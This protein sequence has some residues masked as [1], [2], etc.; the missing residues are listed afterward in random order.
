MKLAAKLGVAF[1][2]IT[3]STVLALFPNVASAELVQISEDEDY[4]DYVHGDMIEKHNSKT[5]DFI[6]SYIHTRRVKNPL[7]KF[8]YVSFLTIASCSD[9]ESHPLIIGR[10]LAYIT[11]DDKAHKIPEEKQ[12][13]YEQTYPTGSLMRN[14]ATLVCKSQY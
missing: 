14:I 13:R 6:V 11:Q 5:S 9:G 1:L 8:K 7:D 10:D 2:S 3:F 4:I 12:K